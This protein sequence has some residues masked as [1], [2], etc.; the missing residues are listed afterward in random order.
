MCMRAVGMPGDC[1]PASS[2]ATYAGQAATQ[3]DVT[4]EEVMNPHPILLKEDMNIKY[5]LPEDMLSA[6]LD[7]MNNML[8]LLIFSTL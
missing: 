3:L 4:V 8:C 1:H 6:A 5:A 2:G 7:L